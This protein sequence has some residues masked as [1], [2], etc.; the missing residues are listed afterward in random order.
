MHG[1]AQ[2]Y[3][4]VLFFVS[5]EAGVRAAMQ[6]ESPQ[7]EHAVKEFYSLFFLAASKASVK[8]TYVLIQQ[9]GN[10]NKIQNRP[11]G[12]CVSL[13][14]KGGWPAQAKRSDTSLVDNG[15]QNTKDNNVVVDN[16]L[17]LRKRGCGMVFAIP[18]LVPFFDLLL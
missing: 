18:Y 7:S 4:R 16:M 15:A 2:N 11:K 14:N 5:E 3:H 12:H 9:P 10:T 1:S 13:R 17:L 8:Q 6:N